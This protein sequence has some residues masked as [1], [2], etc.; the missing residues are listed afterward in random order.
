VTGP[1]TANGE[2]EPPV[3]ATADAARSAELLRQVSAF[4]LPGQPERLCDEPPEEAVWSS[5]VGRCRAQRVPGLLLAAIDAG[6]LPVTDE[7]RDQAEEVHLGSMASVLRLERRLLEV[8][9]ALEGAGLAMV[10]LKG[11]ALAHLA[12]PD[13]SWRFFGDVDVLV[14]SDQ[15]AA[16]LETLTA[17]FDAVRQV[18]EVRPGYD[19]RFAKSVTL[20]S[21]DGLELDVHRNL[22][23]GTFGFAIDRDELFATARTFEVGG[24]RIAALGPEAMLLHACYHAGLGDPTPRMNSVRDVAQLLLTGDHDPDRVLALAERWGSVAVL[25]RGITLCRELL[26]IEVAGPLADATAAYRPT[27]RETRAIDSYVGVNRSHSAKMLASLPFIE[28]LGA[29]AAFVGVTVLP[30][31]G[32][33]QQ[34]RG[35]RAWLRKG[36][37]SLRRRWQR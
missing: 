4:G 25:Q 31:R 3:T 1:P 22:V 33:L 18:P 15:L 19:R 20:R 11:S 6:A 37:R 13:P 24:R 17:A 29:K 7:Q 5:L 8:A 16:A 9:E 28:G 23:F 12:Y 26:G 14:R 2:H 35:L 30:S 27:A 34:R 21:A 10:A 36:W 32:F